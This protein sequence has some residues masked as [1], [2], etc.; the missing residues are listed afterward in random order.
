MDTAD[1]VF[2]PVFDGLP[3]AGMA[4]SGAVPEA[5]L[6]S[7]D[8]ARSIF[9][10]LR[11]ENRINARNMALQQEL[12]DGVP[13]YD[14]GELTEAGMGDMTNLNF[15]GAEEQLE[16]AKAPYSNILRSTEDI[17]SVSTLYGPEEERAEL[18]Q[19]LSEEISR[20]IRGTVRFPYQMDRLVHK[21]VWE[22][23]GI[24]HWTDEVDWRPRAS[25]LGHFLFPRSTEACE[26]EME[27]AT[28]LEEFT[29]TKLYEFIKDPELA[30]KS[31][32][33]VDAV[34]LAIRKA[35]AAV[36]IYN[37]WE[38][39]T[40][41]L[42]ANDISIATTSPVSRCIYLF[43]REFDGTVSHYI[44]TEQ[45]L[46]EGGVDDFLYVSRSKY[47]SM[48]EAFVMFPY[49]L[50]TNTK[51]HSIR[52]LGYKIYAFE[53]QRNRSLCRL[54]DQS[55]LA[56]SLML[57]AD[58]EESL[59]NVGLQYFGNTAIIDPNCK[60]ANYV[61]PD[62]SK[63]VMPVLGEMERLRNIRTESYSSD[64]A[65]GGD[66]R[67]TKFEVAAKLQQNAA[68]SD[69][70][71]DFWY[72]PFTRLLQQVV[73]RMT[74]RDYVS[75]EPGGKEI[76]DLRL[77]LVKRGVPLE[78]FYM[79]DVKSVT[80]VRAIGNGSAGA[81]TLALQQLE[82]LFPRMDDVGQ[83]NYN[84]DRAVDIVGTENAGRYF[85]R[86]GEKRITLDTSL[87][88]LQNE[89]LLQGGD[90]PVLP[91]EKHL[92]HAREHIKPLIEGFQAEQ[93]GQ[94]PIEEIGPKLA[95]LYNHTT[96]HVEYLSND[97]AIAEEAAGFR[98]A[99]QQIGEV[100][101]NGIQKANRLAE[102]QQ[103]QQGEQAQG[104][105]ML[106]EVEISREKLRQSQEAHELKMAQLQETARV[107]NAIADAQAAA[108]I[109]RES[110]MAD[111]KISQTRKPGKKETP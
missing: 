55:M 99:L 18:N 34:N 105:T 10:R 76:V 21:H 44:T 38:R 32:W 100:V 26:D 25:G 95:P 82:E 64:S 41:K 60:V 20:T 98:Q 94:V 71:L 31:G 59:A 65:F 13:P 16:K 89:V 28:C 30:Q 42:K 23:L 97:P 101:S 33:N 63:S 22:G 78:A 54:I 81:K 53:Q 45:K 61:A 5:R 1:T 96:Q 104:D 75:Q 80:A 92:A 7:T 52:G 66:Q 79:I 88:L 83:A 62:L 9:V 85:T 77:R 4:E 2:K 69:T 51:I 27:I 3:L 91:G 107:K 109:A 68:L 90:V 48:S 56:S 86:T 39:L 74:R 106:G 72:T 36:P 111:A 50:G 35:T 6:R 15:H 67:K 58:G 70:A 49:G 84:R 108:K 73:R 17:L 47:R 11:D 37:D 29:V 57:Q 87:A 8:D 93:Q 14:N 40:E 24:A 46:S 102:E 12:L 43:V 110:R 103:G 19:I